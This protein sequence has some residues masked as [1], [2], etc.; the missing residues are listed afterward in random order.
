L[1]DPSFDIKAG[2]LQAMIALGDARVIPALEELA[3][4]PGLPPFATQ[5][6][7]GAINQIRNANKPGEK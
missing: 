4:Q 2:A 7:N 1:K 5:F 6:I 3:K